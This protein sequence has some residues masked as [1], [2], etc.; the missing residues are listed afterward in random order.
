MSGKRG[1]PRQV[2]T[3]NEVI[4]PIRVTKEQKM[5]YKEFAKSAGMPLSAWLKMLADNAC[6]ESRDTNEGH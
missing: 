4:S 5:R 6:K 2:E 3:A 1:R